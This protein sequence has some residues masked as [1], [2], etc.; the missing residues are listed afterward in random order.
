MREI[1]AQ[2]SSQIHPHSRKKPFFKAPCSRAI[3]FRTRMRNIVLGSIKT[4]MFPRLSHASEY[5]KSPH[6]YEQ[7]TEFNAQINCPQNKKW[8]I[9]LFSNISVRKQ[10]TMD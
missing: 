6:P 10:N 4:T 3:A 1:V 8:G 5:V 2:N 9:L 7:D